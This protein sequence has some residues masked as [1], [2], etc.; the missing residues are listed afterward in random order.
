MEES[1]EEKRSQMMGHTLRQ[2][3]LLR[4]ILGGGDGKEKGK[5]QIG[6]FRPNN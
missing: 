1:E 4:N 6:I 5:A 3:G 2:G